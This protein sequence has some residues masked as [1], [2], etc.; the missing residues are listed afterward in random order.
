MVL[1]QLA[2]CVGRSTTRRRN[3]SRIRSPAACAVVSQPARSKSAS[4]C[5]RRPSR[6][7]AVRR[8]QHRAGCLSATSRRG[9]PRVPARPRCPGRVGWSRPVGR[10]RSG[11]GAHRRGAPARPRT[12]RSHPDHQG[13]DMTSS[14]LTGDN[15]LAVYTG[16]TT[17][18][19]TVASTLRRSRV[20][21]ARRQVVRRHVERPDRRPAAA[22]HHDRCARRHRDG[23]QRV[24]ATAGPSWFTIRWG[25]F[26]WPRCSY[27]AARPT[28]T[29]L[30][31]GHRSAVV[32]GVVGVL[33]DAEADIVHPAQWAHRSTQA[34][35][36]PDR[37][38][39]GSRTS[40]RGRCAPCGQG[41]KSRR[42]ALK[43]PAMDGRACIGTNRTTLVSR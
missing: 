25:S 2:P 31:R 9:R 29:R 43:D 10:H 30:R 1:V 28:S 8:S 39:H 11:P 34:R 15:A 22:A 26:G 37:H 3:A 4:S 23:V 17:S 36:R 19:T 33:V 6:R 24:R 12:Q 5:H 14:P 21:G 18:W 13:A 40:G 7:C 20:P 38:G 41:R 42:L 27:A 16:R 35:Q 32:A